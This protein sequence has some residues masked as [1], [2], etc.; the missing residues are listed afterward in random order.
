MAPQPPP[1]KE[2]ILREIFKHLVDAKDVGELNNVISEIEE[3]DPQ[4]FIGEDGEMAR[5]SLD[6]LREQKG[7]MPE[8][9]I[10][11]DLRYILELLG[12]RPLAIAIPA[13]PPRHGG[14]RRKT[15]STRPLGRRGRK[16][17]R[18]SLRQRK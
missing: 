16:S 5:E 10:R 9:E 3:L 11:S 12:N 2:E 14:R 6:A 8:H 1:S 17:R 4:F 7:N 18:K 13:Y 15:R